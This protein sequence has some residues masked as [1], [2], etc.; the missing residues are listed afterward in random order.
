MIMDASEYTD[1]NMRARCLSFADMQE[2]FGVEAMFRAYLKDA[3]GELDGVT[4]AGIQY[5]GFNPI[6][7]MTIGGLMVDHNG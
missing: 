1:A 6:S 2:T 7:G 4:C 3:D 5:G